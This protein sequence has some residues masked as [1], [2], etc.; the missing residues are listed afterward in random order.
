MAERV[1]LVSLVWSLREKLSALSAQNELLQKQ[2]TELAGRLRDLEV[3]KC[4]CNFEK[5]AGLAHLSSV[6]SV[7]VVL[8]LLC[9][10]RQRNY[11]RALALEVLRLESQREREEEEEEFRLPRPIDIEEV[12]ETQLESTEDRE[13]LFLPQQ[14]LPAGQQSNEGSFGY[15]SPIEASPVPGGQILVDISVLYKIQQ[16][17]KQLESYQF[18]IQHRDSAR[19]QNRVQRSRSMIQSPKKDT[20]PQPDY[21]KHRRTN[22]RVLR[23]SIGSIEAP[24]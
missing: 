6:L 24:S 19:S 21:L 22:S 12:A 16:L 5:S 20:P 8:A 17:R 1:N 14:L 2:R 10:I 3:R 18:L 7:Y 15:L 23:S 9:W 11:S 4:N 13:E